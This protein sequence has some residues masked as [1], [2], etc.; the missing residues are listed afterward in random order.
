MITTLYYEAL[1]DLADLIV[2][3]EASGFPKENLQDRSPETWFKPT[4]TTAVRIDMDFGSGSERAADSLILCGHDLFTQS[5]GIKLAWDASSFP[6]DEGFVIGNGGY[7]GAVSADEPIWRETFIDPGAKRYWSLY[8]N[9][10]TAAFH[11]G[12][13]FLGSKFE[14][15][16]FLPRVRRKQ[17]NLA[18]D[19][20]YG[21]TRLA[22]EK[23]SMKRYRE[24]NTYSRT[25]SELSN[26]ED[27]AEEI[28]SMYHSI[29]LYVA[30]ESLL[31]QAEVVKPFQSSL[32]RH[33]DWRWKIA[34]LELPQV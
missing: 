12:A 7:H 30:D 27:V 10:C 6:A 3:S 29:V 34:F 32:R 26:M 24:Y 18:I 8:I 2:S 33:E 31:M 15:E 21:G 9:T 13:I 5:S 23:G 17:P 16:V 1:E 11:L 4:V 14:G 28:G 19:Y 22:V 20:T 25:T